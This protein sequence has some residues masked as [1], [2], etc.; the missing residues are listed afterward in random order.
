MMDYDVAF[1]LCSNIAMMEGS[2]YA[3]ADFLWYDVFGMPLLP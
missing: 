2:P 1:D 3:L